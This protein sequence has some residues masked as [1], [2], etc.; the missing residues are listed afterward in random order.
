MIG[1]HISR[2]SLLNNL[3]CRQVYSDHDNQSTQKRAQPGRS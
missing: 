3:H 1:G 2:G